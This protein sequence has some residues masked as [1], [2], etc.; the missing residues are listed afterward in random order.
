MKTGTFFIDEQLLLVITVM[1][2]IMILV[3]IVMPVML[4]VFYRAA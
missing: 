2:M 3:L 4:A 1:L